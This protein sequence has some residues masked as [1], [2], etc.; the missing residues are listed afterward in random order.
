MMSISC[1]LAHS[2]SSSRWPVGPSV[3]VLKELI[4]VRF[5]QRTI[6]DDVGFVGPTLLLF[7]LAIPVCP[8]SGY[9]HQADLR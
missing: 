8:S 5:L 6:F 7:H 1:I 9:H 2:A 4:I 3:L